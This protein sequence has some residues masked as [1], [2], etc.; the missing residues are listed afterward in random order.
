[1]SLTGT[2]PVALNTSTISSVVFTPNSAKLLAASN[3]GIQE[4]TLASRTL[5]G[6]TGDYATY[7]TLSRDGTKIAYETAFDGVVFGPYSIPPTYQISSLTLDPQIIN[8]GGT[9]NATVTLAVPAPK[10]G[11]TVAIFSSNSL[12][13][14]VPSTVFVP[15]GQRSASTTIATPYAYGPS[16]LI[17]AVSGSSLTS[18]TLTVQSATIGLLTFSPATI[19]GGTSTTG[20]VTI[21]EPAGPNG[22]VVSLSS[23]NTFF[24]VPATVTVPAGQQTATF[25]A[26]STKVTSTSQAE[27]QAIWNKSSV[28][29]YVIV[30]PGT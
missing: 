5:D 10:G 22:A 12:I 6:Y 17:T 2:L 25:T 13:F 30:K 16:Y 28:T 18:A 3:V 8:Q 21:D 29:A 24:I 26:T 1:M 19:I 15:A 27:I 23:Y 11:A 20:T 4:F 9:S 7:V 14:P